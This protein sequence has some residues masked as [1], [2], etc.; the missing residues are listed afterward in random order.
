MW[1]ILNEYLLISETPR[2]NHFTP[3]HLLYLSF[4][5]PKPQTIGKKK[6]TRSL[7]QPNSS[8]V[9]YPIFTIYDLPTSPHPALQELPVAALPKAEPKNGLVATFW[10][11]QEAWMQVGC[12]AADRSLG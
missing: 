10:S 9:P 8:K 6:E 11:P 7:K 4:C 5:H 1:H 3:R 12:G 2:H